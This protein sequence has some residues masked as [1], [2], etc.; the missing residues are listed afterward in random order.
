MNR[1]GFAAAVPVAR[2]AASHAGIDAELVRRRVG[3]LP[4][5][6]QA[7]LQ[8][9]AILRSD[10]PRVDDCAARIAVDPALTARTLRLANSA[11]YGVSGRVA[12][13]QDAIHVLGSQTLAALLTTAA[14]LPQLGDRERLGPDHDVFWRHALG[15]ALASQALARQHGMGAD[16]AFT[17]GLL[18]DIGRLALATH[19][20]D[21]HRAV[22]A[23]AA[24]ADVSLLC[25]ERRLLGL[26]HAEVG[27][28]I[29]RHWHFPATVVQAIALHHEPPTPGDAAQ[30]AT[31]VD[32]VHLADAVAHALDLS[33]LPDELVP[34]IDPGSW[35]RLALTPAQGLHLLAHTEAGV[36]ALALALA[37][38]H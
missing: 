26:D 16:L 13:L 32:I 25:A 28:M 34:D 27:A 1:P 19:F 23:F 30:R 21:E 31:L 17:A 36:Q 22:A 9:L 29:A 38:Q 8:A 24:E 4:A 18:H 3:A 11:F 5:L 35:D 7:V 2:P 37:P 12:T 10:H 33:Q 6:P 14:V 15:T 20:P